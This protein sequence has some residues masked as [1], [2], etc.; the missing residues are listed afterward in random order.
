MAA[1]RFTGRDAQGQKVSGV[2]QAASAWPSASP[3]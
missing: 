2:R 1:F 3:R